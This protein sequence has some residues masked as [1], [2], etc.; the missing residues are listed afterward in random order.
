MDPLKLL[1]A[2]GGV[3]TVVSARSAQLLMLPE[4]GS[5]SA[6]TSDMRRVRVVI[7][8]TDWAIRKVTKVSSVL[9]TAG[10]IVA[11]KDVRARCKQSESNNVSFEFRQGT[12]LRLV[13]RA[14]AWMTQ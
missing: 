3:S 12:M 6:I 1:K 14:S 10:L 2:S 13:G 4:T 11:T 5:W 8:C 9:L 7:C